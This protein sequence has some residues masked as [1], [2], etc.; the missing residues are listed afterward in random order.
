M[1]QPYQIKRGDV[2]VIEHTAAGKNVVGAAYD[3]KLNAIV[4]I[5]K[6]YP[7]D[8]MQRAI[9][10]GYF[11]ARPATAK[12]KEY[13]LKALG[14]FLFIGGGKSVSVGLA[15]FKKWKT[16]ANSIEQM[17]GISDDKKIIFN[18]NK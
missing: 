18:L 11:I 9:N 6:D 5:S 15:A 8:T 16:F 1:K 13:C 7:L 10:E 3:E 12:E 17:A 2:V 4:F 14:F